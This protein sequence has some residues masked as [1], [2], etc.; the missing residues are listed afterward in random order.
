MLPQTFPTQSTDSTAHALVGRVDGCG[1][2]EG[3]LDPN[4]EKSGVVVVP[5]VGRK[6]E[7]GIG[8]GSS[9]GCEASSG[10]LNLGRLGWKKHG[11]LNANYGVGKIREQEEKI[12]AGVRRVTSRESVKYCG[13][14]MLMMRDGET[15]T[16]G[17]PGSDPDA[18]HVWIGKKGYAAF[19]GVKTCKSRWGCWRCSR[20]HTLTAVKEHVAACKEHEREYPE[21]SKLMWTGTLRHGVE[22][23]LGVMCKT[24]TKSWTGMISGW[25]KK[26]LERYGFLGAARVVDVTHGCNGYHPHIHAILYFDRKLTEEEMGEVYEILYGKWAKEIEKAGYGR[27]LRERCVLEEARSAED[28]SSY[29]ARSMGL[30]TYFAGVREVV[31]TMG[32]KAKAGHRTIGQIYKDAALNGE[33]GDVDLVHEIEEEMRSVHVL[34]KTKY[35]K[36]LIKRGTERVA[37][38]AGEGE[39]DRDCVEGE[40]V[41]E[42]PQWFYKA[43]WERAWRWRVLRVCELRMGGLEVLQEE[44]LRM[45][46]HAPGAGLRLRTDGVHGVYEVKMQPKYPAKVVDM[47]LKKAEA[48]D[49][50]NSEVM[51]C[52]F[53]ERCLPPPRTRKT[54]CEGGSRSVGRVCGFNF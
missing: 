12:D 4:R 5:G 6:S 11:W 48:V 20:M 29:M 53:E 13:A 51:L 30:G 1:V 3:G 16:W 22:N 27:P 41:L 34:T 9:C 36:E 8:C 35:V 33:P 26:K 54:D 21:S 31:S 46:E 15:E 28:V 17:E 40:V 49:L 25:Q 50:E 2:G 10:E 37:E 23:K 39:E 7:L 42:L 32:K 52:E 24:I 38:E 18:V 43:C 14:P 47:L 44:L 45:W 19:S